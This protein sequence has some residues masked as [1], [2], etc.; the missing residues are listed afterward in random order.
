MIGEEAVRQSLWV[1]GMGS[2]LFLFSRE[3]ILKITGRAVAANEAMGIFRKFGMQEESLPLSQERVG[4]GLA[5]IEK[6][7]LLKRAG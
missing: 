2:R 4:G 5:W 7:E 3:L 1:A 6:F